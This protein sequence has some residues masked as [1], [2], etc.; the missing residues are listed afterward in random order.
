MLWKCD[1]LSFMRYVPPP[2][3]QR[4]PSSTIGVRDSMPTF[5][6]LVGV[7][8][9]IQQRFWLSKQD[10]LQ[11]QTGHKRITRSKFGCCSSNYL[12]SPGDSMAS[13]WVIWFPKPDRLSIRSPATSAFIAGRGWGEIPFHF[14]VHLS[15]FSDENESQVSQSS[16]QN[17]LKLASL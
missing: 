1:Y 16:F 15:H 4:P 6:N 3:P 10:H 5:Y 9:G 2:C 12:Q 17:S 7:N 13:Q 11:E 8:S 14:S